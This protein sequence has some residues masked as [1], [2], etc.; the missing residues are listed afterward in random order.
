MQPSLQDEP[1]VGLEN[2]SVQGTINFELV[3]G[4]PGA[5][6]PDPQLRI[7]MNMKTSVAIFAHGAAAFQTGPRG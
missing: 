6:P 2:H 1:R 7:K 4:G 3:S 5:T